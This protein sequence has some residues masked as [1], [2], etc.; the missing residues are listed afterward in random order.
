[1]DVFKQLDKM[2]KGIKGLY[3]LYVDVQRGAFRGKF[4]FL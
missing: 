1:M 2:E 4:I 3:P